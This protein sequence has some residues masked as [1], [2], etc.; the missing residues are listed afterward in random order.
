MFSE[1]WYLKEERLGENGSQPFDFVCVVLLVVST[2]TLQGRLL[3]PGRSP[4]KAGSLLLPGPGP[5]PHGVSKEG[6]YLEIC[7][8]HPLVFFSD[9]YSILSSHPKV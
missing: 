3:H 4:V 5:E 6:L 2:V 8:L 9:F 7:N 1:Q